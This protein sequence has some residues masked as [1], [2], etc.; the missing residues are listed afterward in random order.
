MSLAF[1]LL[2]YRSRF[3]SK[4]GFP[5]QIRRV[6]AALLRKCDDRLTVNCATGALTAALHPVSAR[7]AHILR[8]AVGRKVLE[9]AENQH[10]RGPG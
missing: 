10:Q 9:S 3:N 7:G 2:Q 8:I 5:P 4:D 1:L 6:A